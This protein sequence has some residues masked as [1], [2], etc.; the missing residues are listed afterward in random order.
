M[1]GSEAFEFEGLHPIQ[2]TDDRTAQRKER[3][4]KELLNFMI[5]LC[6]EY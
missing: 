4:S 2:R 5:L 3:G 6:F 1:E